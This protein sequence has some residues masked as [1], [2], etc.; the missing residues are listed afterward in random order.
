MERNDSFRNVELRRKNSNSLVGES[1]LQRRELLRLLDTAK[2]EER[3][4]FI[5]KALRELDQD[6]SNTNGTHNGD[7]PYSPPSRNQVSSPPY[8]K[9]RSS[10]RFFADDENGPLDLNPRTFARPS[11]AQTRPTSAHI[12]RPSTNLDII[13]EH[14][15]LPF[16]STIEAQ[17][18]EVLLTLDHVSDV[19]TSCYDPAYP[20]QRVFNDPCNDR[21]S[22]S[23]V[24]TGMAPQFLSV[25]LNFPWILKK[26]EVEC[27]GVLSLSIMAVFDDPSTVSLSSPPPVVLPN[28]RTNDTFVYVRDES[29]LSELERKLDLPTK[30]VII[31]IERISEPFFGIINLNIKAA[32]S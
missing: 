21:P 9:S 31:R 6:S 19:F 23:W 25:H 20:P 11:S 17:E 26:I 27:L 29:R 2:D 14:R 3:K 30:N 15:I 24:G 28:T 16:K 12:R 1:E 32:P 10:S 7:D 18:G 22:G 8:F 4:K 5:V 13:P